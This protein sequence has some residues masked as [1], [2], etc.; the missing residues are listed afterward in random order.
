[1]QPLTN[2]L[3]ER[4]PCNVIVVDWTGGNKYPYGQAAGNSRLVGVQIAELIRFL[5]SSNS[6][7]PDWADRFYL[8][9][10]SLGAAP[11]G[12]AGKYLREHGMVLGRITGEPV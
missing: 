7:S 11:I 6:G 10:H 8:V 3:L 5:I 2:A 12:Y 4:E 9:G 1:M